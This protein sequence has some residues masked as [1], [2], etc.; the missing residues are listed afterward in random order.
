MRMSNELNQSG[1]KGPPVV[2]LLVLLLLLPLLLL[3]LPSC[4]CPCQRCPV[5][6][7]DS[8]SSRANSS[9]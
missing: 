4:G 1:C 5:A 2:L 8:N 9:L 6:P 3:L 7:A